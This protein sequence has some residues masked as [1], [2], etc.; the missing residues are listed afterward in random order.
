MPYKI[1]IVEDHPVMRDAYVA[2]LQST[3]GLE[4]CGAAASA[5]EALEKLDALECDLVVTDFRL[6]GLN[7]ADLIRRIHAVQPGLPAIVI[8]AHEEETFVLEA[9]AAGAS[10]VMGKRNLVDTFGPTILAV[11]DK[12]H[13]TGA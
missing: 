12:H 5:E 2:V 6:P 1:F 3:P 10:A 9:R 11:L 8:S 4:L 7:G 13:R